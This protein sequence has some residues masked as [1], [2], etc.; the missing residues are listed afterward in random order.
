MAKNDK[1]W[2]SATPGLLIILLDQSGS[3]MSDYEGTTRTKFATL[4]VNKVIDNII[5]KNFDGDA[6]KNRCFISVIGYNHNVKE[7]CSGWL[8]DLD[9]NPLRYEKIKKKVIKKSPDGAGGIL[10]EKVD[11][12]VTQPVWVEPIDRDGAT[13]MLGAFQLAKDLVEK[14]MTDNADGPAPV[15]INISD[16]VPYYEGKDPRD[17]MTETVALAN[18]I[19]NLSNNDGNVLIFN[20][21]IDES[22]GK[23]V[24]P[25]NRSDISQEQAQFLYDITSE[26]PESYKKAAA[27]N[28]LPTKDGCR[29]CIFGADGVQLIQLIDFGSSKGQGDK[30]L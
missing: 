1:Q 15:I 8:K 21:Q 6:P 20:A 3:M 26:V 22:N 14:W 24:F 10:E 7:L 23:V 28:E 16:G 18:E 13:N 11:V 12:E 9:A 2:S 29:G 30:G 5:Q 25:S 27:K 19:K 17:C 4:A